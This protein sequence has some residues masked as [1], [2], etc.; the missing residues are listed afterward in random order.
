MDGVKPYN[1]EFWPACDTGALLSACWLN[2]E[3]TLHPLLYD[4]KRHQ[5]N[6]ASLMGRNEEDNSGILVD[7]YDDE[8]ALDL[9]R[10]DVHNQSLS[11]GRDW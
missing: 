8:V 2:G 10:R 6:G 11:Y 4:V 7:E 5:H 3:V 1:I 9:E